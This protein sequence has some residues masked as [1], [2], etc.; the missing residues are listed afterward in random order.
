MFIDEGQDMGGNTLKV[1]AA[2][3][4]R[5]DAAD[6]KSRSINIF[7]Q[8]KRITMGENWRLGLWQT[9][10]YLACTLDLR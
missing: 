2:L 5:S 9:C 8:G 3:V 10:Q 1:L 7:Y 4:R 6:P